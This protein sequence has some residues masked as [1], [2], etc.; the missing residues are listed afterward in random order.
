MP[1]AVTMAPG[2]VTSYLQLPAPAP[3]TKL[4]TPGLLLLFA[5]LL[6]LLLLLAP[7]MGDMAPGEA[8]AWW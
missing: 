2:L 3:P 5:L 4:V 6:L 1:L 8:S 7:K